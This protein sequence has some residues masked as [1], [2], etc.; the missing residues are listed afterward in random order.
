MRSSWSWERHRPNP[1]SQPAPLSLSRSAWGCVAVGNGQYR[2][3]I[4]THSAVSDMAV[5]SRPERIDMRGSPGGKGSRWLRLQPPRPRWRVGGVAPRVG[6]GAS[7]DIGTDRA[8]HRSRRF[9]EL[10]DL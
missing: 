1:F 4:S 10:F 3:G 5:T 6:P 7:W 9:E 2:G 8:Q